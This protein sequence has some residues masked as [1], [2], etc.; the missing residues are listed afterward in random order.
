MDKFKEKHTFCDDKLEKQCYDQL[1]G[2]LHG[3]EAIVIEIEERG[4]LMNQQ[5]DRLWV[6]S[7]KINILKR[8]V[9]FIFIK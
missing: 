4:K 5:A 6:L 3:V 2:F 1:S 7:T 9:I 8:L